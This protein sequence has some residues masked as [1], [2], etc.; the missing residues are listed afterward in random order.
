M[1]RRSSRTSATGKMIVE[2]TSP[3]PANVLRTRVGEPPRAIQRSESQP[4]IMQET[5][6]AKYASDPKMAIFA[7]GKW[8]SDSRY[9]GSQVSRKYQK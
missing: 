7:L 5:A 2:S 4:D 9:V 8:R 3:V 6:I 1:A